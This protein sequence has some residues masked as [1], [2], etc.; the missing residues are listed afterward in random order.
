[1]YA[2][3][4][5]D[6]DVDSPFRITSLLPLVSPA[7]LP[8][9]RQIIP[10]TRFNPLPAVLEHE[11]ARAIAP[12]YYQSVLCG[13]IIELSFTLS[14]KFISR[15]GGKVSFFRATVDEIVILQTA[16]TIPLAPSKASKKHLFSSRTEDAAPEPDIASKAGPSKPNPAKRT[17]KA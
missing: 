6:L 5:L 13:A 12:G 1:M 3:V 15:P 14:H 9:L 4:E 11:R 16:A 17:R 8:L 10:T 7:C 2:N